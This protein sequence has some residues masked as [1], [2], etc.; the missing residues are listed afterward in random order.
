M[1]KNKSLFI[2]IS[3][4]NPNFIYS[5]EILAIPITKAE[6]EI[7]TLHKYIYFKSDKKQEFQRTVKI[8]SS[9]K[10]Y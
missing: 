4:M 7:S 10:G 9:C 3:V 2:L 6:Q 1:Q 5:G 8:R